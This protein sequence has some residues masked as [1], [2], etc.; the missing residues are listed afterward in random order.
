M[1]GSIEIRIA[2]CTL[3]ER[4]I[5]I[6]VKGEVDVSRREATA[7]MIYSSFGKARF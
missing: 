3:E 1:Q 4:V 5:P 7:A 6:M 2:A